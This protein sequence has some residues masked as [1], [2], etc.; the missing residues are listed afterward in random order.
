M[1]HKQYSKVFFLQVAR[2]SYINKAL[3]STSSFIKLNSVS[4][5]PNIPSVIVPYH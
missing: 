5:F 4:K 3:A 1:P 2:A